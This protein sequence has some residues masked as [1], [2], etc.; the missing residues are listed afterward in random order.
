MDEHNNNTARRKLMFQM[1]GLMYAIGGSYINQNPIDFNFEADDNSS[2][3][4][5]LKEE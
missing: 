1:L 5:A 4:E 3:D 2:E